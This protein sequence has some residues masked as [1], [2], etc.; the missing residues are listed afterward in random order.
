MSLLDPQGRHLKT[1]WCTDMTVAVNLLGILFEPARRVKSRFDRPTQ[2]RKTTE[3]GDDPGLAL[4]RRRETEESF[5]TGL[6]RKNRHD[7]EHEQHVSRRFRD[8]EQE[9]CCIPRRVARAGDVGGGKDKAPTEVPRRSTAVN[10]G[11][12]NTGHCADCAA[13][14]LL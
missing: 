13:T 9:V 6:L 7:P 1:A 4:S 8:I 5:T 14:R 12:S 10:S 11:L 3:S 2:D